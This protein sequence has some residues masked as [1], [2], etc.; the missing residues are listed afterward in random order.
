MVTINDNQYFYKD[1]V[2]IDNVV[3]NGTGDTIAVAI[4]GEITGGTFYFEGK[5][6]PESDWTPI[7]GYSIDKEIENIVIGTSTTVK[8]Y[9]GI[10]GADSL[11]QFR[12]RVVGAEGNGVCYAKLINS[13]KS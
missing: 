10:V 9:Y 3:N 13:I 7:L 1:G 12:V 2:A 11:I 4:E 8:G 5:M 6:R